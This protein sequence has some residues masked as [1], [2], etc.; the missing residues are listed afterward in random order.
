MKKEHKKLS[1]RTLYLLIGDRCNCSDYFQYSF[2]D[3][4]AIASVFEGHSLKLISISCTKQSN[5]WTW[6]VELRPWVG[7][8]WFYEGERAQ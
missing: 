5:A 3:P 7:I 2:L 1:D 6:K 4:D 8:E